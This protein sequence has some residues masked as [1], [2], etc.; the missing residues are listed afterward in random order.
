ML[1]CL[2]RSRIH[3]RR[4]TIIP[5]AHPPR[6]ANP[7][8]RLSTTT[9]PLRPRTL[10]SE[11]SLMRTYYDYGYESPCTRFGRTKSAHRSQIS[12]LQISRLLR[13]L[14]W[15]LRKPLRSFDEK[16]KRA[17]VA[18]HSRISRPSFFPPH[19]CGRRRIAH[20]CFTIWLYP[21]HHRHRFRPIS[22][23]QQRNWKRR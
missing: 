1:R 11:A 20:A 12:R 22:C 18:D 16:H 17:S 15:Q 8:P 10:L 4:R 6:N 21:A 7:S 2:S 5:L 3:P 9:N 23:R 14:S 19:C 13:Q